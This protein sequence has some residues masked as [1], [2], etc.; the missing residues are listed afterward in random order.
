MFLLPSRV[1]LGIAAIAFH[2]LRVPGGVKAGSVGSVY[3]I[4]GLFGAFGLAGVYG[5]LR[6][7]ADGFAG[8]KTAAAQVVPDAV[9]VMDPFHVVALAGAK[10][11]LILRASDDPGTIRR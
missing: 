1:C 5:G 11:D 10:L 4:I 6:L 3:G 9:T 2:Q 8:Y 7:V